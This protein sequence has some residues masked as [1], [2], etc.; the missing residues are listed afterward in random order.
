MKFPPTI[1]VVLTVLAGMQAHALDG[2]ASWPQWRGPNRDGVSSE[3]GW[4]TSWPREGPNVLWHKEVGTGFSSVAVR[5]RRLK[6]NA[7]QSPCS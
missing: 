6:G 3:T 7:G 1:A 5:D 2:K 4:L